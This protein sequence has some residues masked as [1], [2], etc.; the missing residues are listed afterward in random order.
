M[1]RKF[2]RPQGSKVSDHASDTGYVKTSGAPGAQSAQSVQRINP[3]NGIPDSLYCAMA[4]FFSFAFAIEDE[5][6]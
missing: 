6:A 5:L 3:V 4:S 2:N 1:R